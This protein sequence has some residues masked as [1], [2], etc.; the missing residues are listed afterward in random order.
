M[1]LIQREGACPH[2]RYDGL[3]VAG[4]FLVSGG[5]WLLGAATLDNQSIG[6]IGYDDATVSAFEEIPAVNGG[7][8]GREGGRERP[9]RCGLPFYGIIAA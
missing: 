3:G 9:V 4:M 6:D 7:D 1:G 5:W 8:R 2:A